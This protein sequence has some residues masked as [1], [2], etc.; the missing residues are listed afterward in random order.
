MFTLR[1]LIPMFGLLALLVSNPQVTSSTISHTVSVSPGAVVM[2]N[3]SFTWTTGFSPTVKVDFGTYAG[4]VFTPFNPPVFRN[5]N[6]LV[7]TPPTGTFSINP[8]YQG[9]A[10]V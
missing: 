7:V 8:G 2:V 6:I 9:T 1:P 4:G 5:A 10:G 3:G